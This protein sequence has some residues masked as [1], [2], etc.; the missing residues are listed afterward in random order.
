MKKSLLFI[1]F[2]GLNVT[3]FGQTTYTVNSLGDLPDSNLSDNICADSNGNC[4]LRAAIQNANKTSNKDTIAFNISGTA[5]FVINVITDVMTPIQKPV[6]LDGRTQSGYANAPLIE[7]DGSNLPICYN[8]LQL[9]GTSTGSEIYGLS[10]GGFKRQVVTPFSFGFGVFANTGN[11][12]FQSNYIGLKPDGTTVNSNTGGGLFFNNTSG[13]LIGG[14]LPNQK[15]VISGNTSGGLTFQGTTTNSNAKNNI[16]QGN[17]IGTDATG[18]LNRGNR[19][20]VQFVN[21]PNNILGGNSAAARNIISGSNAADD[22]S[23]GTGIAVS[24]LESYGNTIIGNYIGTDITGTQSISNVRGGLLVLFGANNNVI[25]TDNVGEGNLISGNGQYGIYLQGN[26]ATPVTSN[27]IKGNYIGVDVTGNSALP[28]MVGIMMLS[29]VNN[30]NTIG[31]LTPASKNIISGNSTAGIGIVSGK[32]NQIIGNYIGTNSSGTAA[33]PNGIGIGIQD[34]NNSIGGSSPGSRNIISGNVTGIEIEKSTSA[35]SSVKGNYIGL[36]VSGNAA[37]ANTTGIS[38]LS[39]SANCIIGGINSSDRNI[40]S[41]NND[42]GILVAGTAHIIQNNYIGLSPNGNSIIKNNVEGLRLVGTLTN[43]FVHENTISG[44]G[45]LPGT[46]RNVNFLGANGVHFF[47][48]KVGT[49]ADGV[50]G[51]VNVGIGVLLQNSSNNIIGGDSESQGN[52]IGNNNL[53]GLYL[54]FASNNNIIVNNKIGVGLDNTTNL[55]NGM[56]AININGN[57]VG[58]TI[59]KNRIANSPKGVNIDISIGIPTQ[60]KISE[61]SIYNNLYKGIQIVGTTTNDVDDADTGANNLQNSPEISSITFLGGNTIQIT[62]VV[63][64]ST[65]NSAYPLVV[66]FFGAVS[67]QGK[68]FID[69]DVYTATGIKTITLN[70]PNGF[71]EN[72]YNNI[73]ATATDANGNTSE[74]GANVS[75]TLALSQFENQQF[76][77]YPNPVSTKLFIQS[78]AS[79]NYSFKI[80]N[81]VGQVVLIQNNRVSSTELDVSLLSSGLYFLNITSDN[82]STQTI[83]FIKN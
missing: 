10:I 50:T 15:N 36:N 28:N 81:A 67:G 27:S 75:Y 38:L 70:L 58:N 7:I 37:L 13:N 45:T 40:I 44:N 64:S 74:F 30:N 80:I 69:S 24:G 49:L 33:V 41:G 52:I 79:D 78:V 57:I 31:G 18:T 34:E 32:N 82:S 72:D 56:N 62:Y 6:I 66:E 63:P 4:T 29:G 55:G 53:N 48:N 9:I 5:P 46:S 71:T 20:N 8:G 11:H 77:I 51:V 83:K 54:A 42:T 73:V 26:T 19:F 39:T 16:V 68:F 22:N 23:V 65:T 2:L 21:A 59:S 14:I 43:T 60:V 12:I 3:V 17:L 25:G 61:N 35:G 76:K 47:S 1:L